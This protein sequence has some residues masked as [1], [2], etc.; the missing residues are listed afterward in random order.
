MIIIIIKPQLNYVQLIVE[1]LVDVVCI[2]L[3]TLVCIVIFMWI[4]GFRVLFYKVT[5]V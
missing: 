1:Y 5:A 3:S 4:Y 2:K